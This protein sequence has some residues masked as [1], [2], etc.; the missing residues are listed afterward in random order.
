M[1]APLDPVDQLMHEQ[2][3]RS[4][5]RAALCGK[6]V[7]IAALAVGALATWSYHQTASDAST[8]ARAMNLLIILLFSIPGFLYLVLAVWVRRQKL[9]AARLMFALAALDMT[10]LGVILITFWGSRQGVSICIVCGLFVVTLGLLSSFLGRGLEYRKRL[11]S[12]RT[13]NGPAARGR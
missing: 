7:G 4:F 3:T 1:N 5:H 13:L 6:C 12:P 9:W 11:Q 10:M 8:L 2:M